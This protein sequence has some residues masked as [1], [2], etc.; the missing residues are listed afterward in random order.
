MPILRPTGSLRVLTQDST[1][2]STLAAISIPTPYFESSSPARD[3]EAPLVI[4][5]TASAR[6]C[7][8]TLLVKVQSPSPFCGRSGVERGPQKRKYSDI[9]FFTTLILSIILSSSLSTILYLLSS[10]LTPHGC[11]L[12]T[13]LCPS[14]TR[15]WHGISNYNSS[16]PRSSLTRD[17]V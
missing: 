14:F 11:A 16:H 4:L 8:S 5:S 3:Q 17:A 2:K 13:S 15:K 10:R 7:P 9:L 1:P 12:F 6:H